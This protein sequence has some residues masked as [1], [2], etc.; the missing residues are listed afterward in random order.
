MYWKK[1]EFVIVFILYL[2]IMILFGYW[3]PINL[4]FTNIV[5]ISMLVKTIF[6]CIFRFLMEWS[7]FVTLANFENC[8]KQGIWALF[9]W[10]LYFIVN[11]QLLLGWSLNGFRYIPHAHVLWYYAICLT[12][13]LWLS[14][15]RFQ[16]VSFGMVNASNLL[17]RVIHVFVAMNG[18]NN[19][20]HI[21]ELVIKCGSTL[22]VTIHL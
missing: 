12:N 14:F 7:L 9:W 11:S 5:P 22:L 21:I 20:T 1:C 8:E 6:T 17:F 4:E 10:S 18:M 13:K 16:I 19:T 3:S 15:C 2:S